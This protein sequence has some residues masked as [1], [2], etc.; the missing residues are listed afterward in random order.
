MNN[1]Y[2]DYKD[3]NENKELKSNIGNFKPIKAKKNNEK[4]GDLKKI[5]FQNN[6]NLI[7]SIIMIV[8]LVL[9]IAGYFLFFNN[10]NNDTESNI[11]KNNS[12]S[13]IESNT[14]ENTKNVQ[15]INVES[16]TRPYA[17]MI[18]CHNAALP[19]SGVNNAYIVYELM[20]EGGIT[21]MMALFKDKDFDKVG[22]VRSARTQ[23]LDYVY[24]NDAIYVHAG[25]AQDALN[26]IKD[27]KINDI[28]VDGVYGVRDRTLNRAWEHTLFTNTSLLSQGLSD[29]KYRTTTEIKNILTYS[30]D[31]INLD[32]FTTKLN[33]NNISIKYSD[34][35]TSN[36]VYDSSKQM[37]LRS[38]N[39][40]PNIDLVTNEQYA[41]KN[42]IV[43]G[44]KYSNYTYSGY[45]AYQK[46]D[47]IGQGDG[48]YIT[49]GY[50][51]PITWEKSSKNGQTIYKYKES[52]EGLVVNDGNTYI[53]IYPTSGNLSIN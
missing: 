29:K 17:I 36:Y 13:Q 26:R 39:N 8:V 24:E 10:K 43:Y 27:E 19:Q 20:V 52:G 47:N 38:M 23:Y 35:R 4:N 40:T 18:N 16:K 37:Y 34:Y 11:E 48:Y 33:A 5:S 2:N 53:Q 9:I 41:V 6:K 45:S 7:L 42:I 46:I 30:A 14:T 44:V 21:R 28:D 49:N 3:L 1:M 12:S 50:A 32:K 31:P 25:G 22:S 51:I 15:I